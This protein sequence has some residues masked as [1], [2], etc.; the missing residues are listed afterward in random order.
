MFRYLAGAPGT[1]FLP[2]P[3]Y[4]R[5]NVHFRL[6]AE[7]GRLR[8]EVV[9]VLGDGDSKP[10]MQFRLIAKGRPEGSSLVDIRE[11]MDLAHEWVVRG[12]TDM[13]TEHVHA[14]WKR[15]S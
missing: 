10:T 11:W 14:I 9:P 1:S 6:P 15:I 8:A 13:T 7:R 3:E 2:E 12:F 5:F 4:A